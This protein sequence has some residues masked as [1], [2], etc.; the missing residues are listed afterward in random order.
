MIDDLRAYGDNTAVIAENDALGREQ[1]FRRLP[2]SGSEA[3]MV[4]AAFNAQAHVLHA[5]E[6]GI[7]DM[8]QAVARASI[9][10]ITVCR[11]HRFLRELGKEKGRQDRNFF[12]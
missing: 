8:Q 3:I 5:V 12:K 9:F 11:F 2:A 1:G 7:I 6:S 4:G 10:V